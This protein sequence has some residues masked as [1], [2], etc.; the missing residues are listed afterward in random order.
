MYIWNILNREHH[1][2]EVSQGDQSSHFFLLNVIACRLMMIL[3]ILLYCAIGLCFVNIYAIIYFNMLWYYNF[4]WVIGIE[5]NGS[6]LHCP[7]MNVL[8]SDACVLRFDYVLA[9][10]KDYSELNLRHKPNCTS[11]AYPSI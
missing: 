10:R 7:Y 9:F 8:R 4:V 2:I 6:T 3:D 5:L 1:N 11:E